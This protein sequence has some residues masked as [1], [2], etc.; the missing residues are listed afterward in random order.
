MEEL[1]EGFGDKLVMKQEETMRI[2]FQNINGFKGNITASHEVFDVIAEKEIDIMGVA[3]I[4][5][6]WTDRVKQEAQLAV[7]MRFGQGQVVAISTR[8]SKEGYLP[9]GTA[10]VTRGKMT[11][12]IAR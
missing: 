3:E 10:I 5:V 4:N 1:C 11:G 8:G 2:G 12:R 7:Q 6:N 9:G